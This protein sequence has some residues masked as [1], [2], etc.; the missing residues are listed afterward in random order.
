[1]LED[2]FILGGKT[3]QSRL[4]IGTARYPNLELMLA[5]IKAAAAQIVTVS[6]RRVNLQQKEETFLELLDPQLV[7]L[8]NTAGCRTAQEAILTAE[9]AR[10]ALQ[11]NWIKVEVIGDDYTLLPDGV[12]LLKA[13]EKLVAKG[14]VVLPYCFDDPILCKRLEAIGCAAVMPL[15]APIGSGLGIRTPHNIELIRESVSIPIIIDAGIGTASD[16]ALAMELGA[17]A[18]LLN[19]AV[20][21]AMDPVLMAEAMRKAVEAGRAAYRAGRIPKS[22]YAKPS[23]PTTG[24]IELARP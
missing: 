18:V 17:D 13:C 5:A 14:F 6:I 8:P 11:T 22:T 3:F 9:L 16:A 20:A 7:L 1:M 21:Q 24:K 10:E 19:T 12:E 15:A 4:L 2:P 23:S